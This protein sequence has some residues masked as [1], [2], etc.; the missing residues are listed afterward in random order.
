M[1]KSLFYFACLGRYVTHNQ[2]YSGSVM[3]FG[4]QKS[5]NSLY[6]SLLAGN[7]C[8]R[9]VSSRLYAPPLTLQCS[10]SSPY[11]SQ[12]SDCYRNSA[13]IQSKW[14]TGLWSI[15]RCLR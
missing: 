3:S 7:S 13:N 9:T 5:I 2:L 6:F 12:D 10:E 8:W 4:E 11:L 1:K 15:D 14:Q